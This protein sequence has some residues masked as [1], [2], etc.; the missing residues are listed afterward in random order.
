MLL[1]LVHLLHHLTSHCQFVSFHRNHIL[2]TWKL[3]SNYFFCCLEPHFDGNNT[4]TETTFMEFHKNKKSEKFHC[5]LSIKF[6]L[7]LR[8]IIYSDTI[9][10]VYLSMFFYYFSFY[11]IRKT[12]CFFKLIIFLIQFQKKKSCYFINSA[13]KLFHILN[14]KVFV[15]IHI[16]YTRII[17]RYVVSFVSLWYNLYIDMY[18]CMYVHILDFP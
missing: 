8:S 17:F 12:F 16:L 2:L 15:Y 6:S 3:K 7:V 10:V 13:H 5:F 4:H 18:I 9:I 1:L 14:V 11:W